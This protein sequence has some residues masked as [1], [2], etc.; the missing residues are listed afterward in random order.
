MCSCLRKKIICNTPNNPLRCFRACYVY[1]FICPPGYSSRLLEPYSFLPWSQTWSIFS[2]RATHIPIQRKSSPL[3]LFSGEP[4]NSNAHTK[5]KGA[6]ICS[7]YVASS[8]KET[9]KQMI[10]MCSI[11]H[12]HFGVFCFR[13]TASSL[14][15]TRGFLTFLGVCYKVWLAR[16]G[17][18]SWLLNDTASFRE[19][20]LDLLS[21][22]AQCIFISSTNRSP[23]ACSFG[24]TKTRE[25]P[26]K[27][28]GCLCRYYVASSN[29]DTET[30]YLYILYP[31]CSFWCA[32]LPTDW[33][34][35]ATHPR[36]PCVFCV[37][38]R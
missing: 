18:S 30:D 28:K 13:L 8:N 37:C 29:R 19:H 1:G 36:I 23:P 22:Y 15:H 4:R 35:F 20:K 34:L 12:I 33:I 21:L 32:L 11:P 38:A 27:T 6:Y 25:S 26:H 10:Y 24:G 9:Q 16:P 31:T 14:Q 7:Y 17:Y 3:V 2:N 5:Q